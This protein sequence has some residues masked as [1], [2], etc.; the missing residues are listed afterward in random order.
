MKIKCPPFLW[1]LF[2][3]PWDRVAKYHREKMKFI[4]KRVPITRCESSGLLSKESTML[5]ST[6]GWILHTRLTAAM[7]VIGLFYLHNKKGSDIIWPREH[8]LQYHIEMFIW[9]E[10]SDNNV[11]SIR[12]LRFHNSVCP[13][14]VHDFYFCI[15]F[16]FFCC[17]ILTEI[18][19]SM[20]L[21]YPLTDIC[22]WIDLDAYLIPEFSVQFGHWRFGIQFA[23]KSVPTCIALTC[24]PCHIIVKFCHAI[25]HDFFVSM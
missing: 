15:L 8:N 12:K 5:K 7:L 20:A 11:I 21:L 3:N 16:S 2:S 18:E 14:S 17:S 10:N 1:A 4:P 24:P 19:Y 22:G 6:T 23:C 13:G 9:E 25:Y